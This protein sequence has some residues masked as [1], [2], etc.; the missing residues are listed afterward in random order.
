MLFLGVGASAV[1]TA[2]SRTYDKSTYYY[3]TYYSMPMP[4]KNMAVLSPVADSASMYVL[5][6]FYTKWT[7]PDLSTE[8]LVKLI[9][10]ARI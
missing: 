3:Y 7:C 10:T 2:M 5:M 6:H 8:V 1:G 9:P 4:S